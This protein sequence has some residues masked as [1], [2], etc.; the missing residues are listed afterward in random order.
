VRLRSRLRLHEHGRELGVGSAERDE[1][2]NFSFP[3]GQERNRRA[4][5]GVALETTTKHEVV[6]EL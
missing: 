6:D 5:L 1:A 2:E 3:I 4:L